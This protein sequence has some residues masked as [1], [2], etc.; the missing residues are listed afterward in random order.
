MP[1]DNRLSTEGSRR[2]SLRN[3]TTVM[4]PRAHPET[5]L[6]QTVYQ[7]PGQLS[8]LNYDSACRPTDFAQSG[9]LPSRRAL[10]N[11]EDIGDN[12][13]AMEARSSRL[14]LLFEERMWA[15]MTC[16]CHDI[17]YCDHCTDSTVIPY[18]EAGG[19]DLQKLLGL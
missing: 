18:W 10:L 17:L 9:S 3:M 1:S 19:K 8:Q 5:T 14:I 12:E 4:D 16:F 15:F 2:T 7:S 11:W 13:R 6:V